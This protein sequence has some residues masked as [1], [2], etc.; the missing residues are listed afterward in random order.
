MQESAKIFWQTSP[1]IYSIDNIAPSSFF[2]TLISLTII[3]SHHY[4]PIQIVKFFLKFMN[5]FGKINLFCISICIMKHL[6]QKT[7]NN[8]FSTQIIVEGIPDLYQWF[9]LHISSS[10][11]G[12]TLAVEPGDF[13][14]QWCVE[15]ECRKERSFA[16]S[17]NYT[18]K[19]HD[20]QQQQF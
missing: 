1:D 5:M 12:I 10:W 9:F 14:G 16:L 15:L 17:C 7:Q 2:H 3:V 4:F 6:N 11:L 18:S 8:W 13:S 20:Q 19:V